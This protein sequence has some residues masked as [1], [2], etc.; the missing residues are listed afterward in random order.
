VKNGHTN[1]TIKI[2]EVIVKTLS[3]SVWQ[4]WEKPEATSAKIYMQN[5]SILWEKNTGIIL[6]KDQYSNA[7]VKSEYK[8]EFSL[9]SNQEIQYCIKRW[10]LQ[11]IKSIYNRSCFIDE[12]TDSLTYTYEDTIEWVLIFD[13]KILS[14]EDVK[15][16][17]NT[18]GSSIASMNIGGNNPKWLTASYEYYDEVIQTLTAW[19]SDGIN[20]WYFL[21]DRLLSQADAVSW[22]KNAAKQTNNNIDWISSEENSTVKDITREEFMQLTYKYLWNNSTATVS[23]D[24]RDMQ[25]EK[26]VLVASLL[27]D[28]YSWKDDFWQDYFQPDK[29]ITRWEATYMLVE[30][31]GAQWQWALVRK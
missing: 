2:W 22:I 20:K 13:Y 11:D 30:A 27:W 4:E 3:I 10:R 7:L 17:L 5:E 9:S 1:I 24:Y 8:W 14:N 15:I 19:I 21:E 16:S 6:M 18:K 23:R 25:W 28:D 29:E 26:A 31:L 12:Y